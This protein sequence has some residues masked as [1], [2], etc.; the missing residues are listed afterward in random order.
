MRTVAPTLA[1]GLCFLIGEMPE[2]P[3]QLLGCFIGTT[4]PQEQ[5]AELMNEFET[6]EEDT[7]YEEEEESGNTNI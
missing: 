3:I 6:E 7:D 1:E 5:Q 2:N 4:L